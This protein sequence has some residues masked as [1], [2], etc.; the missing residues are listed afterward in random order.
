MPDL[1]TQTLPLLPLN[2]GV[3]LP[4]MVVTVTIETSEAEAAADAAG[5]S[6]ELVLV[7]RKDGR[8]ATVGVVAKIENSGQLP[9]GTR[10]LI[11]RGL[12]RAMIG[13]GVAGQGP[14]TWVQVDDAIEAG[15]TDRA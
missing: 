9:N 4:G 5:N 10:A 2:N 13:L 12:H 15:D 6:G 11:V 3:V 7:P 8:Y 14:A 1:S